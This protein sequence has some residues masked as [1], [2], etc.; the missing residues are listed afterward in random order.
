MRLLH[1]KTKEFQEFFD[2]QIPPYAI[3]SHTWGEQEATFEDIRRPGFDRKL[4]LR[5]RK[6]GWS[7]I[8]GCCH[9]AL[10]DGLDWVWIDTCN[11]DKSSSAELSEAINSMFNWY[12]DAEKCYALLSD[13]CDRDELYSKRPIR[14]FTRGWTLQELLAP[15]EVIFY[16]RDWH[17]I[18]TKLA[19]ADLI[20]S[21][22]GINPGTLV[23]Q[24]RL[25]APCTAVKMSWAAQRSTSRSEDLAYCLMGLFD[26][27]MPTLY[28]EGGVKAFRRLQEEIIKKTDDQSVFVWGKQK[29]IRELGLITHIYSCKA[30]A[31]TPGDFRECGA[32]KVPHGDVTFFSRSPLGKP[33]ELI[34]TNTHH[35]VTNR[36]ISIK[37]PICQ[38]DPFTYL[39]LFNCFPNRD[40]ESLLAVLYR[41]DSQYNIYTRL[42]EYPV[43]QIPEDQIRVVEEG[44]NQKATSEETEKVLWSST[45]IYT[46]VKTTV[47][48]RI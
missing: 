29:M 5:K 42:D 32:I 48:L 43:L 11:I 45:R 1:A 23:R 31:S 44:G 47:Y 9:Q 34:E 19:D 27:N 35:F 39:V 46:F 8:H 16:S 3:L 21:I 40:L 15:R 37:L 25:L 41:K 30:F 14:W 28:G 20:G 36:G 17:Q 4:G 22:T 26:V 38:M 33:R 18:A 24:G 7:K 2:T 13:V 10:A 6:L 12:S